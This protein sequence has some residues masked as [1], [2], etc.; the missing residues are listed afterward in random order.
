[1]TRTIACAALL[2]FI[3]GG[4]RSG[5]LP[6]V[7]S[8][9]NRVP[10]GHLTGD[11]LHLHLVVGLASWRPEADS[12]P[13]IEVAVVAEE[14][15]SP[16]IPAPLIRIRTGT[17]IAASVRNTLSDSTLRVYGL[18]TR[19]DRAHDSLV[20]APGQLRSV[21]FAAGA[22]GTYL[23]WVSLG[24]LDQK[25]AEREQISGAFIVDPPGGSPPDRVLVMNIW[26]NKLDSATYR[27]ALAINGRSWPYTERL[28]AS[29][30]DTLRWRVL[31]G[32]RRNHPMHLHGFYYRVTA[33]GDGF[34]DT[35]YRPADVRQAVTETLTP[36]TTMA[37]TW[38][39]ERPG[40]WLFHCHFR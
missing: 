16:Q 30:G 20:I 12:G 9:D 21:S 38:V 15:K 7:V 23:Y 22:P 11:T 18:T 10:A 29:V 8:N 35:L 6:S 14:G 17:V 36:R 34:A 3:H 40:N 24:A 39:P 31:N 33:R 32:T 26:G 13:S 1:M 19:P 5:T 27:N 25:Q 4:G 2:L 28:A 37:M